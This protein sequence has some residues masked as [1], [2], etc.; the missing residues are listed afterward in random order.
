MRQEQLKERLGD[1]FLELD[2]PLL[3]EWPDGRRE[4]IVFVFEEESDVSKFDIRSTAHYCLD[5][6]YY[7]IKPLDLAI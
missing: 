2:T 1:R 3:I 7:Y 5:I 6:S 4:A